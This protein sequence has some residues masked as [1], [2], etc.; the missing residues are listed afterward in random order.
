MAAKD[1]DTE[2]STTALIVDTATRIFSDS[3]TH[4]LVE[5]AQDGV[6]PADLWQTLESN[7]LL[8]LG[9]ADSGTGLQELFEFLRVAGRFAVPLPLFERL[10]AQIALQ[11]DAKGVGLAEVHN[12]RLAISWPEQHDAVLALDAAKGTGRLIELA[13]LAQVSLATN[14]ATMKGEPVKSFDVAKAW[15]EAKASEIEV[16]NL[17]ALAALGRT[18][19]M[20][21]GLEAS[22]EL[23]ISY[24]SE[25]CLPRRLLQRNAR[26]ILPFTAVTPVWNY[27]FLILPLPRLG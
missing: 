8:Q 20:C 11:R 3:C 10:L 23:A 16:P 18:A 17:Y 12:G 4:D 6:W 22:L 13:P 1:S 15:Q 14:V 26:Q 24:C 7:G 5:A 2:L 27:V 21:G 19:A 9:L 25:R